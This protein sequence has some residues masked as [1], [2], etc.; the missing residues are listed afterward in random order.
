M[1]D[2]GA[3]CI[4]LHGHDLVFRREGSG[5][6]ILLIHGMAGSRTAWDKVIGPLAAAGHTVIAP[7]LPGH[8][9]SG[10]SSGDSSIGALAATLRDLILAL[11]YERAT[12]AGHS[13]GGGVAMQFAYLFPEHAERLVLISSGGLGRTVN[14]ALR[15]AALPG[16]EIVVAGIGGVARLASPVVAGVLGLLRVQID[17]EQAEVGRSLRSLGVASTRKA[18]LDTLR[19]VV[20]TDGQRVF[21]GDRLYLTAQMP[22][23]IVWGDED[24][25]IPVGH[26]YRGH[27]AMPGSE[28]VILPGVGHFPPL[29]APE[30][31]VGAMSEF[32]ARVPPSD[33][34]PEVWRRLLRDGAPGTAGAD[35]PDPAA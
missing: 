20:G 6:V 7:D 4:R 22:T 26:G 8:G 31:L 9:D 3:E 12:L 23:L 29:Q 10:A 25:V 28:L 1:Y 21:A 33:P 16:A 34:K 19:A 15:S 32:L 35:D 13:L 5:P 30:P 14:L 2:D 17:A 24:P 27:A 11:G 18:F